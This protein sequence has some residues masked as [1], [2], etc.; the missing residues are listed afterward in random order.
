MT[1]HRRLL[2]IVKLLSQYTYTEARVRSTRFT[3]KHN[4]NCGFIH[5]GDRRHVVALL[6]CD[7]GEDAQTDKVAKLFVEK[8]FGD[9]WVLVLETGHRGDLRA[10]HQQV[11]IPQQ[12]RIKERADRC[13]RNPMSS[14]QLLPC[15]DVL[16]TMSDKSVAFRCYRPTFWFADS[17]T[18]AK[19]SFARFER[20][21]PWNPVSM[22]KISSS[23]ALRTPCVKFDWSARLT[24][25]P[26]C[27]CVAAHHSAAHTSSTWTQ[28]IARDLSLP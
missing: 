21:L 5:L 2:C 4:G 8:L 10:V 3:N 6:P 1:L 9:S 22:S 19:F 23:M 15:W 14:A 11:I 26:G 25:V 7:I 24:I 28:L 18:E 20:I 12:R 13:R 17:A 27:N 16:D